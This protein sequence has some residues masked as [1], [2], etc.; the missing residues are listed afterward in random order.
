MDAN[1]E[2]LWQNKA[3][4]SSQKV[5]P[6]STVAAMQRNNIVDTCKVKSYLLVQHTIVQCF[7]S[8]TGPSCIGWK[9]SQK[10]GGFCSIED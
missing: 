4:A 1:A 6:G 2:R 5:E 3:G 9:S 10:N 7:V 8:P